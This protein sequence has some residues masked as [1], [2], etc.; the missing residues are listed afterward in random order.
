LISAFLNVIIYLLCK[1][2]NN[3][4]L[5]AWRAKAPQPT[6]FRREPN[7]PTAVAV[8]MRRPPV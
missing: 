5:V 2:E 6:L 8:G 3:A 1:R 4:L 7:L